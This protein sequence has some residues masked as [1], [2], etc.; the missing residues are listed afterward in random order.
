MYKNPIN[1]IK[2]FEYGPADIFCNPD[3]FVIK[4]C[5]QYYCY[6]SGESGVNI[7]TSKDLTL[8]EH[9][10]FAYTNENEHSYWAPAVSYIN[11]VFYLYYSSLLCGETDDHKHYLRVAQSKHPEGP[12]EF[13]G[14]MISDFAIDPHVFRTDEGLFL[15]YSR[16]VTTN[17]D[18]IGTVIA[19]DRMLSPTQVAVEAKNIILPSL[20]EEIFARNRFGDGRDWHTIEGAFFYT[21]EKYR[22]IFYSGNAYTSPNYFIGYA[23]ADGKTPLINT[24]FNK[25]PDSMIYKPLVASKGF[26]S[27]TGHNSVIKAPDNMTDI[28]VFHGVPQDAPLDG[29]D[30]RQLCIDSFC[31]KEGVLFTNAPSSAEW[32]TMPRATV[33]TAQKTPVE[34]MHNMSASHD[35]NMLMCGDSIASGSFYGD[36]GVFDTWL[37]IEDGC[38]RVTISPMLSFVISSDLSGIC[39]KDNRGKCICRSDDYCNNPQ[40][41]HHFSVEWTTEKYSVFFDEVL[42]G[43]GETYSMQEIDVSLVDILGTTELGSVELTVIMNQE[44]AKRDYVDE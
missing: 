11:G 40:V 26:I 6:S 30:H 7:L 19:I 1:I 22:Y 8:F 42:V 24:V 5:G 29:R 34:W 3:P 25:Y 27:G 41:Y 38:V 43:T 39:V 36:G 14:T 15:L 2:N 16:N 13:I 17:A 18:R 12:F 4:F 20:E 32:I 10:G 23:V 33:S 37:K 21:K 28:I 35:R 31:S 44:S 9:R